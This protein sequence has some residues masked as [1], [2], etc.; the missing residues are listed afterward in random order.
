M[1]HTNYPNLAFSD[2]WSKVE[3]L[4]AFWSYCLRLVLFLLSFTNC[5]LW[6]W[7]ENGKEIGNLQENQIKLQTNS[8]NGNEP[9]NKKGCCWIKP[10]D[11]LAV[12]IQ[13]TSLKQQR[14]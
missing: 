14:E 2:L 6:R 3:L 1:P 7:Y 11:N 4:L 10:M 8:K 9:A 5:N 12:F 13:I